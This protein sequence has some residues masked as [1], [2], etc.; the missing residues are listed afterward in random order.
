MKK[1]FILLLFCLGIQNLKAQALVVPKDLTVAQDG[2]GD[3]K[4]IQE[5]VNATRDLGPRQIIIHIKKRYLPRKTDHPIMENPH[6]AGWRK[7]R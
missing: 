2:S 3:F 7:R 5:A 4:T 1:I 6:I